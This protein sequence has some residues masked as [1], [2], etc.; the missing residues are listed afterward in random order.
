MRAGVAGIGAGLWKSDGRSSDPGSSFILGPEL[1]AS[2]PELRPELRICW[3]GT[4][5]RATLTEYPCAGVARKIN[6]ITASLS[7]EATEQVA[8]YIVD[9]S[10]AKASTQRTLFC[11]HPPWQST[12]NNLLFLDFL[13]MI[14]LKWNDSPTERFPDQPG[15]KRRDTQF[16]FVVALAWSRSKN[17]DKH[18]GAPRRDHD[19]GFRHEDCRLPHHDALQ[20]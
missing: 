5:P 14:H 17:P 12:H 3:R 18:H 13:G 16:F 19:P 20:Q 7:R 2:C 9:A 6:V 11:P 10:L 8:A 15:S 4:S 1:R